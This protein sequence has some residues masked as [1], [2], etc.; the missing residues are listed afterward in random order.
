M[1]DSSLSELR[2]LLGDQHPDVL[3]ATDDLL[4]VTVDSV[5]ARPLLD[6]LAEMDRT[7]PPRDPIAIAERLNSKASEEL[8]AGHTSQA[9]A[10]FRSTLEIEHQHLAPEHTDARTVERNLALALYADRQFAQAETMQRAAVA[11]E[12][13]LH[14]SALALATAREALAL[15]LFAEGRADSAE[16]YERGALNAFREG[17]APEHWRIWSA[18]RNLAIIA[19]ARGR[20]TDA[21]ALIDSAIAMASTGPEG[22][23]AAGYLTAQRAPFLLRLG[24]VSEAA[25]ATSAAEE[26][27]GASP[28]VSKSHRADVNRYAGMVDLASGHP[29]RAAARFRAAI[30][31]TPSSDDTTSGAIHS[32]L[33]G[34]ALARSGVADEARPLL[35]GPCA[36]YLS[37][38]TPD[39]LIAR[40]IADA[41]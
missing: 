8:K 24:R 33:L 40:W 29:A 26:S 18:Q 32:C 35:A 38:G 10:L 17:A 25:R 22:S 30:A 2:R 37:T 15:T 39:A 34:I 6:R 3:E 1:L 7:A 27:L 28:A 5:A 11:L 20:V 21:L 41:R 19:A 36:V 4:A 13:R 31:L 9:V 12:E 16:M 14:N 23:M